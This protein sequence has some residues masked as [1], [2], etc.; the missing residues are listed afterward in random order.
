MDGVGELHQNMCWI[1]TLEPAR[2]KRGGGG[3][4]NRAGDEQLTASRDLGEGGGGGGFIKVTPEAQIKSWED[5]IADLVW[6]QR[7]NF[8]L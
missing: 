2:R 5:V 4:A 7:G 8:F 6:R 3:G 1:L